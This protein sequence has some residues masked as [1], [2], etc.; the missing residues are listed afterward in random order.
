MMCS[1]TADGV[2]AS[3]Q[4]FLR[5][6]THNSVAVASTGYREL[7]AFGSAT[8]PVIEERIKSVD[9]TGPVSLLQTNYLTAML[10]VVEQLDST[11]CGQLLKWLRR[12]CCHSR[13][14]VILS[15]FERRAYARRDELEIRGIRIMISR[16]IERPEEVAKYVEKWL[17]IP[18]DEDISGI[19]RIDVVLDESGLEYSGYYALYFSAIR[20]TWERGWRAWPMKPFHLFMAETTLYHEIGHHALKHVIGGQEKEQEDEADKYGRRLWRKAH[21]RLYNTLKGPAHL[22][23]RFIGSPT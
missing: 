3:L 16:E 4:R 10:G 1:K 8:L 7:L 18:P 12:T 23:Y 17:R 5:G 14:A 9:W 13:L 15:L 21:P 6:I 20:L 11:R 22:L 19:S 2:R